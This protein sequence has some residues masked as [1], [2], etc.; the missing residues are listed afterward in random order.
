MRKFWK[1]V[2]PPSVGFF[3]YFLAIRYSSI[4]FALRIDEMGEGSV[5][6]FMAYYRYLMP[7][8]YAVAL[9]TQLLI[10]V[11]IWDKVESVRG[12]IISW[13][14]L[15]IVCSAFAGGV[16]YTIWDKQTGVG[17]LVKVGLFMTG[18]QLGYW[19]INLLV[20]YIL[21]ERHGELSEDEEMPT[22]EK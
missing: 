18:V 6:A 19:L 16:S 8:L 3:I 13:I 9:L 20:L 21:E 4:Y 1:T 7:L 17:H 10:A 22:P 5:K 15:I 2:V 11:P 14:V 12:K